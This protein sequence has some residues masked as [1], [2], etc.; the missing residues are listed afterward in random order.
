M[1]FG[2][3]RSAV[4]NDPDREARLKFR[5]LPQGPGGRGRG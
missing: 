5:T 1:V 4:E 3:T 2:E